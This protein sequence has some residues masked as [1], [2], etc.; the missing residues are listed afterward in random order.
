MKSKLLAVLVLCF[1]SSHA[2]ADNDGNSLLLA[3]KASVD[4]LDEQKIE[5]KHPHSVGQCLGLISGLRDM[6]DYFQTGLLEIIQPVFCVP[7]EVNSGQLA[8]VLVK[9][10]KEN[11]TE[12]HKRDT[13]LILMA[14][15][16]GFP[17]D[18]KS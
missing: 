13:L 4:F 11:P 1:L 17:C 3:C 9:Y 8:R 18:Q 6:H 14:F 15:I 2:Y 16:D 7:G 12:L 5:M 10:L